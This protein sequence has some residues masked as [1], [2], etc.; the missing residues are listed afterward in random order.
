MLDWQSLAGL[1]ARAPDSHKGN[2]GHVLVLG[3]TTGMGGAS[4]LCAWA[5]YRAGAGLVSVACHPDSRA[6]LATWIPEALSLDWPGTLKDWSRP[7]VAIAIGPGMGQGLGAQTL[8]EEALSLPVPQVLDADALNL[9]AIRGSA[10]MV[11]G[12]VRLLTPH[13]GEA[14]RLLGTDTRS[15]QADRAAA[16]LHLA[17]CYRSICILKGHETL[18]SDGERIV[19]CDLGNPGMASGGTGDVLTGILAALLAQQLSPWDAACFGV[20]LH[21]RA[22]DLVAEQLGQTSIMARDLIEF[23]P[24]AFKDHTSHD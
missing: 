2:Y 23:L 1:P 13:P 16:V 10:L 22:G 4:A 17:R 6:H 7:G 9:L 24:A 14:A 18:I 3:G 20:C 5:A 12:P 8:L 21:G 11:E 15:V 19:Q